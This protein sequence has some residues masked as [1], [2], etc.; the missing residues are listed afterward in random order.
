MTPIFL[1]SK[2]PA[3]RHYQSEVVVNP[4]ASK[5]KNEE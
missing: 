2:V 4:I 1:L 3:V 5:K